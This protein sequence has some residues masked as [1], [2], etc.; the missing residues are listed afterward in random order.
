MRAAAGRGVVV[1]FRDEGRDGFGE[2]LAEGRALS[3]MATGKSTDAG[4]AFSQ[5]LE[6]LCK[7]F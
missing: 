1:I 4:R 2:F 5:V 6:K 7:H 3:L